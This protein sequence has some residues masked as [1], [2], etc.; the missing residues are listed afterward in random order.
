MKLDPYDSSPRGVL[1]RPLNE[2][3]NFAFNFESPSGVVLLS[4]IAADRLSD[5][6]RNSD[7]QTS[8]IRNCESEIDT[9]LAKRGLINFK[10]SLPAAVSFSTPKTKKKSL[11]VWLHLVNACNFRCHYCYIPELAHKI[12]P[13]SIER[14]SVA[15]E[16]AFPILEK[17]FNFC[18]NN[19]IESLH[20]KF[21]GGEP[22]LNLPL[23]EHFCSTARKYPSNVRTSFGMITNG[24]FSADSLL[25]ILQKYKINISISIDGYEESHDQVRYTTN[26]VGT[27][28]GSWNTIVSNVKQL[29]A[30]GIQPYFLYTITRLNYRALRSFA[31][32]CHPQGLGFRLSLVRHTLPPP[33][34]LVEEMGNHLVEFYRGL[35]HSL[36]VTL[37]FERDARFAEW[38]L[39]KQKYS[40]CGTCRNYVAIDN[41]GFVSSCQMAM[42]EPQGNLVKE[43]LSTIMDRFAVDSRTALLVNP[44]LKTGACARCRFFHVCAGGCPQHT[45]RALGTFHTPSPWCSVFG[46]VVPVYVEATARHLLRK[47]EH[48]LCTN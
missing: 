32:F 12:D 14:L 27:R 17:L 45:L 33:N 18:E 38:N 43:Q 21:A 4:K 7:G 26:D 16:A 1:I 47:M 25:P 48:A 40:A 41:N 22:T 36:P 39:A 10:T 37:R 8:R 42:N 5:L 28:I 6:L 19:A 9:L 13:A 24:S 31:N 2:T 11:N 30:E 23:L 44:T 46:K 20:L 34:E 15:K 3:W 35:G 29:L